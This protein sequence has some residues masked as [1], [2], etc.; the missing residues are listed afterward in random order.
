MRTCW[1]VLVVAICC[2][3][4]CSNPFDKGFGWTEIRSLSVDPA[5][6]HAGELVE[7]RAVVVD[8][9]HGDEDIAFPLVYALS[10]SAGELFATR[11]D[12]ETRI[13]NPGSAP[14]ARQ[15]TVI[16]RTGWWIAP[17]TPQSAIVRVA[18]GD[19]ERSI[20]VEVLP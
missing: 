9:S 6:V 3:I 16:G 2:C 5:T 10:V 20:K 4:G 19:V 8:H 17:N 14:G 15:I 18:I 1:I 7:I 12:A 11:A 13:S